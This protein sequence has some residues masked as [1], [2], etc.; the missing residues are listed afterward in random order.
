T[1]DF[2][3]GLKFNNNDNYA[4]NI[5]C[6]GNL[7]FIFANEKNISELYLQRNLSKKNIKIFIDYNEKNYKYELYDGF[8]TS[9]LDTSYDIYQNIK[10]KPLI[11][12][13]KNTKIDFQQINYIDYIM[14]DENIRINQDKN[15]DIDIEKLKE[16]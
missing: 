1:E 11:L 3:I 6:H 13:I 7:D 16:I 2:K 12:K 14:F 5:A 8:I 10:N 9:R 4:F 15:L